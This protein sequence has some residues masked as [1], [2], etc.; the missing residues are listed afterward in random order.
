[1]TESESDQATTLAPRNNP[2]LFGHEAAERRLIDACRAGRLHHAWLIAGPR[3]TGKATLAFRF[4]RWLLAGAGGDGAPADSLAL[5]PGHPV[6][7]RTASGGHADLLVVEPGQ[8]EKTGRVREE[9]VVDDVRA[10]GSFLHLTPGEGGWRVVIVDSADAM[11]RNAANAVLKLLEEPPERALLLLI[12]HSPGRLLPTIRS[13]CQ[14]LALQGLATTDLAR[15]LAAL[16]RDVPEAELAALEQFAS[17]SVGRAVAL[18]DGGG[19]EL[20]RE[21]VEL[22]GG[23]LQPRPRIQPAAAHG[24]C[25]RISRPQAAESH[26]LAKELFAW[27]LARLVRT[28]ALG[29]A[30]DDMVPGEGELLS[31]LAG[32]L[33]PARRLDLWQR[34]DQLFAQAERANLD[35]KQTLLGAFLAVERAIRA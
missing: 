3:G 10:V 5:D 17:G 22:L 32:R 1:M 33:A 8:D 29:R 14:T 6:F 28:G 16:G 13:R 31:R 9:I 12:S 4:A 11:N 35:R 26:R 25:E 19:F 30:P 20:Y 34:V 21:L 2:E 18:L 23:L 15:A 24:F 7:R 27:W